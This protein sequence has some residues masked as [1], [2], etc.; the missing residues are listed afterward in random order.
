MECPKKYELIR[1][2]KII[3]PQPSAAGD[4]GSRVHALIEDYFKTGVMDPELV[5]YKR[6]LETFYAKGGEAEKEFAFKWI[7]LTETQEKK[8]KVLKINPL[9][10]HCLVQCEMDDPDVWFRGILDW[11]KIDEDNKTAEVADWKTGK[12]RPSKQ[13][14]LYAW[15]IFL[16]Y[17]KIEK[18]KCTFH[19]I[20]FNDQLPQWFERK[21]MDKLF[22]PFQETLDQIDNCY[23]TDIWLEIPGDI[24]KY[25]GRGNHCRFC[26]VDDRYCSHG[27]PI[28][29]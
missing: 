7:P 16:T 19:W 24:N 13:L 14:Q 1:A 21:D 11:V 2:K 29:E 27:L 3:P 18:V 15:I 6:L 17:P 9:N 20:N 10:E 25:N 22:Q 28:N 26:A 12:V 23:R 8:L 5:K 4:E